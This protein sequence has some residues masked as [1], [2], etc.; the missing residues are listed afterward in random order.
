[1]EG[2]Q[3]A[4]VGIAY[5]HVSGQGVDFSNQNWGIQMNTDLTTNN[6]LG[7]YLFVHSKQTMVFNGSGV[8]VLK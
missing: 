7:V 8:Q 4:G 6:P 3:F 1:M 2:S 5:D